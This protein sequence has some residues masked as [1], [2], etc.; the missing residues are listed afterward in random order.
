MV[1]YKSHDNISDIDVD[2]QI[3]C[4]GHEIERV[5]TFKYLGIVLDPN[6]SFQ[7]HY[8]YVKRR[9]SS[10]IGVLNRLKRF[11]PFDIFCIMLKAFVL[12]IIDNCVC[13]WLVQ[14]PK[15]IQTIQNKINDCIYLAIDCKKFF[16]QKCKG[17]GK[18]KI[19]EN[20]LLEH[21]DIL[22]IDERLKYYIC[23][24]VYESLKFDKGINFIKNLF[25]LQ[26]AGRTRASNRCTL[27]CNYSRTNSNYA[28]FS[29][30]IHFR[31]LNAW[32]NLPE[33]VTD[34]KLSK[35]QFKDE[36]NKYLIDNRVNDRT[37][38]YNPP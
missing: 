24:F 28:T 12:P 31:A 10:A 18:R 34:S 11:L 36:L 6:L 22:S 16:K 38:L 3:Q 33:T 27:L 14:T 23:V 21:V 30:S 1:F 13:I 25:S 17:K 9:L 15:E 7:N 4:F 8:S 37:N 5:F 32:N 26:P 35:S 19:F 29:K 2:L 20:E